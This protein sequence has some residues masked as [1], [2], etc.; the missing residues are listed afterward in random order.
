MYRSLFGSQKTS[1]TFRRNIIIIGFKVM[2]SPKYCSV[3]FYCASDCVSIVTQTREPVE[4]L[5]LFRFH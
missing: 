5:F 4:R 1:S 2:I 3:L